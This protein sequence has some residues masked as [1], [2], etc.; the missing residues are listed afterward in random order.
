MDDANPFRTLLP[1]HT[2]THTHT[3]VKS[4]LAVRQFLFRSYTKFTL[5]E[6]LQPS[7]RLTLPCRAVPAYLSICELDASHRSSDP[8]FD[9]DSHL[10]GKRH[11]YG[12]PRVRW[13][14][15]FVF[16]RTLKSA[17]R[18]EGASIVCREIKLES[19]RI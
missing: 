14:S 5:V 9:T 13:L 12:P 16:Q 2:H 10:Q 15:R 4:P 18:R 8:S 6:N 7:P 3:Q 11:G 1:S 19:F 17:P